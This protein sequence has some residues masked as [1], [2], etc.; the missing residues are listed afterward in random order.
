MNVIVIYFV[1]LLLSDLR[2]ITL[3]EIQFHNYPHIQRSSTAVHRLA[4]QRITS[5]ITLGTPHTS[6]ATALVYQ[7]RGLLRQIEQSPSCSSQ[8]LTDNGVRIT[9]VGSSGLV[10]NLFT[11]ELESLVAASSYLPL[12][13]EYNTRGDGIVQ[14][15]LAF[16]NPPATKLEVQSCRFTDSAVR[17]A[18]VVPTPWNLIDGNAKSWSLPEEFVWYGSEGVLCQWLPFV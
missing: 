13:G 16:M 4:K 6:P 9:C 7:T 12:T 15:D 14:T 3:H 5:L 1:L 8:S 18:H 10:G 17:H 11:T 2:N